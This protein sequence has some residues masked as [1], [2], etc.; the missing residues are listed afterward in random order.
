MTRFLRMPLLVVAALVG[1]ACASTQNRMQRALDPSMEK[2]LRT[3]TYLNTVSGISSNP[4]RLT[5][6]DGYVYM[7]DVAPQLRFMAATG[8]TV[9]Y[10][11]LRTFIFN[12]MMRREAAGYVPARAYRSD[13]AF[14]PATQYGVMWLAKALRDG[15][16]E[17]GDST[18]A[19]MLAQMAE[20]SPP[21]PKSATRMYVLNVA[22]GD[23]MDVVGSDPETARS[24]LRDARRLI[25]SKSVELEQ[26][27]MGISA[28]DGEVDVLS[29][30]TRLSVA[31]NDP[32]DTVRY[33]DHMLEHLSPLLVHSGRPDLGTTADILL[34]LHRVIEVGPK[35]FDPAFHAQRR[36]GRGGRAGQ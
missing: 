1:S 9:R 29:C 27:Q 26:A 14:E 28:A 4:S 31:L 22:C 13:A 23:A 3:T 18:S 2:V 33:L 35:Y 10:R 19:W 5:R 32:D 15:W 25:G 7:S 12:K 6:G 17:L 36:A 11:E 30:L 21:L 24:V 34:T 8:D 20:V 16:Q